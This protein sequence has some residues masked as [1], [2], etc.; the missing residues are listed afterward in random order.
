MPSW[1]EVFTDDQFESI[2]A[3]LLTVQSPVDPTN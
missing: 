2:F 3:F 1:K